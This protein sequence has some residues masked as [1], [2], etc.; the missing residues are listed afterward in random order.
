MRMYLAGHVSKN[1]W[2][3]EVVYE[4]TDSD[5]WN[6]ENLASAWPVIP[7]GVLGKADYVGPY[8][9]SCDH[10]CSHGESTHGITG[11]V[12]SEGLR[13]EEVVRRCLKAIDRSDIVFVWIDK[14][15][16][17]GTLV[18][19]GYAVAKQKR[20]AISWSARLEKSILEMWF[21]VGLVRS[22]ERGIVLGSFEGPR[23]ALEEFF[24][25]MDR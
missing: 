9:I 23:E 5:Y 22:T 12:C 10:G 17:Q 25:R 4:L 15:D 11:G 7:A 18:E 20:I 24:R 2:R 3:S 14:H 13:R 21:A 8:F 16:I 6:G 19:I 1:G